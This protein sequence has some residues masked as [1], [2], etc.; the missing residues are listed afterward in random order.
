[1]YALPEPRFPHLQ[2]R[3]S[4]S[5]L[6]G[7]F[8]GL[9]RN[10]KSAQCLACSNGNYQCYNYCLPQSHLFFF[11]G[12]RA[13]NSS[14]PVQGTQMWPIKCLVARQLPGVKD[15]VLWIEAYILNRSELE[16]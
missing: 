15:A 10:R 2:K 6:I 13:S 9:N 14:N 4:G 8:L 7:L 11:L 12:L 1:M 3:P 5:Y 16:S